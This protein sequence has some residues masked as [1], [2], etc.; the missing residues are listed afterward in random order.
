MYTIFF[1][2]IFSI[3]TVNMSLNTQSQIEFVSADVLAQSSIAALQ[4]AN[5]IPPQLR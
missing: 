1:Y 2:F 4:K 3:S 5:A